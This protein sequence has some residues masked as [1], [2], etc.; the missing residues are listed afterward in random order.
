MIKKLLNKAIKFAVKEKP[1]LTYKSFKKYIDTNNENFNLEYLYKYYK[2]IT[3]IE[4]FVTIRSNQLNKT[5]EEL[6]KEK[7]EQLKNK[8][9]TYKR[10]LLEYLKLEDKEFL[11]LWKIHIQAYGRAKPKLVWSSNYW[12]LKNWLQTSKALNNIECLKTNEQYQKIIKEIT[13]YFSPITRKWFTNFSY[14]IK[15]ELENLYI[16]Q[17]PYSVILNIIRILLDE[18]SI[19]TTSLNKE[20]FERWDYINKKYIN[21]VIELSIDYKDNPDTFTFNM[22]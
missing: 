4:M 21:P 22:E 8:V 5:I 19:W 16:Y 3:P 2:K 6:A 20:T 11:E 9:I 12:F 14:L 17:R 18:N 1:I 13:D 10:S 7:E 15:K